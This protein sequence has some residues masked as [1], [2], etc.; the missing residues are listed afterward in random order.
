MELFFHTIYSFVFI[1]CLCPI[2]M[3]NLF[4]THEVMDW[5]FYHI[6]ESQFPMTFL[7]FFLGST[8]CLLSSGL[9][10]FIENYLTHIFALG[11]MYMSDVCIFD[12]NW[13]FLNLC[14]NFCSWEKILET[15]ILNFEHHQRIHPLQFY[16][17]LNLHSPCLI[18]IKTS[19]KDHHKTAQ[20]LSKN[21]TNNKTI[22]SRN[23]NLL[24]MKKIQII[25]YWKRY[26]FMSWREMKQDIE[27]IGT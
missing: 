9:E 23:N 4:I 18:C 8:Y 16:H 27:E 25:N 11:G 12:E 22:S 7:A 6:H 5:D 20:R 19:Q 13:P 17:K 14:G 26:K 21:N 1:F 2:F 15:K 24:D 3:L 10:Y